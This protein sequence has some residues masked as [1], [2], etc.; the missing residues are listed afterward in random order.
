MAGTFTSIQF[1][2][3][4]STHNWE[5]YI[6]PDLKPRL[7]EYIG[8][9]IRSKGGVLYEIGGTADHV[10]L[11]IR[12]RADEALADLLR[13]LKSHSSLWIH[14]TFPDLR[15]FAWQSGYGAFTVSQSQSDKVK[16]Y[17]RKQVEHHRKKTFKEEF[18][19]FLKAH[20]IEYDERYIWV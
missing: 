2:L 3:V 18:T 16:G 7:Y 4:F 1:H 9:I 13:D 10:H 12:C 5:P 6:T 17:I 8:G 20:Q 19:E 14:Q 11:L 15:N